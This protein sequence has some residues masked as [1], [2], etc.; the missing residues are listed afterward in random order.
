M[1]FLDGY[2]EKAIAVLSMPH[3]SLYM[4]CAIRDAQPNDSAL[5]LSYI[6]KLADYENRRD[7]VTI[8][9]A[10]IRKDFFQYGFARAIFVETDGKTA[11]FAVYYFAYSTFAGRR[12]LF[13]EDIF[14]DEEYR[15]RGFARE[16]FSFLGTI[17]A[18]TNCIRMEWDVLRWNE[19]AL[20][21]Y[22][23]LGASPRDEW[24]TWRMENA[25]QV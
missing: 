16:I 3:G 10:R 22:R 18:D 4:K 11:G 17:A 15:H 9:E 2:A 8:T 14:I 1:V 23:S 13:V 24:Q 21:F 20:S 6:E 7:K 5:I 25:H 19:N 12:S